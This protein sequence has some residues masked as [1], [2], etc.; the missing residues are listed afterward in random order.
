MKALRPLLGG[1]TGRADQASTVI[2]VRH[3]IDACTLDGVVGWAAHPSR[4]REVRVVVD[5]RLTLRG[6][7]TIDRGDV[8][9]ALA[10][11]P[12][13][14]G[15]GFVVTFPEGTFTDSARP[16]PILV[17]LEA[18]DGSIARE[19]RSII[20]LRIPAEPWPQI[21]P[22]DVAGSRAQAPLPRD[23]VEVLKRLRPEV[24]PADTRWSHDVVAR[25]VDDITTAIAAGVPVKPLLRYGLYLRTLSTAFAFVAGHFD[26]INRITG[27][28]L[29]DVEAAASSPDEMLVIA[30]HLYVLRSFGLSGS[31]VECGCFKGFSTCCLSQA[32]SLLDVRM[33]VFDSFAG[34]PPSESSYYDAGD[35]CGTL[36]EV[37]DNLLTFGRP[38]VV[39]LHQ[40]FFDETIPQFNGHLMCLWMDVDLQ[41]SA[42]DVMRLLPAL[43]RMSCVFSH[44]CPPDSFWNGFPVREAT[45]VLPPIIEA[46]AA[47]GRDLM[48]FHLGGYLAGMTD[49][50]NGIR[51]LGIDHVR[52]IADVA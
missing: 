26:R 18:G 50:A 23:V 52:R 32:C 46:F 22:G 28:S 7:T 5:G 35:F 49:A 48:G 11:A 30:N 29:K 13:A 51:M 20:P 31:L 6:S 34:L 3:A 1:G 17:E 12:W 27:P 36:D 19:E 44:E 33:D 39:S 41:S 14:R 16:T 8:V 9:K 15:A 24:Y 25:A 2:P 37:H 43:P 42:A 47:D 40:G 45:E 38:E 10:G 4:I 21:G